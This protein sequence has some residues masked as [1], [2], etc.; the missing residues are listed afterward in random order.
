MPRRLRV[1]LALLLVAGLGLVPAPSSAEGRGRLAQ[2]RVREWLLD[3]A[4]SPLAAW[5]TADGA[6]PPLVADVRTS[7]PLLPAA[8][9][10]DLQAEFEQLAAEWARRR[11]LAGRP[12]RLAP[13]RGALPLRVRAGDFGLQAVLPRPGGDD[14]E[15][16][17]PYPSRWSLLP[18]VLA[19]AVAFALRSVVMALLA[20]G[21]AGAIAHVATAVPGVTLSPLAAGG[22]GLQHYV[23]DALW[24]R[25]LG[26]D[27]Y[28][29]ITL[30][31]LCLFVT[32]GVTTRNGG[33]HGFVDLLQRRVRG[34]VGAQLCTFAGGLL[35]FFDDYS[36]CLLNGTA[37]R[38]LTDR[39]RV[40]REKLA[41]LVDSTAAPVAGLSVVSTWV[42]YEMSQ[43]RLPLAQV[44]RADG[45]AYRP[46]DAFEVFLASLPYRCYSLFALGLVLLVV[47]LRRDF[48]PM[49]A[50][51]RRARRAADPTA[52]TADHAP[53]PADLSPH[54]A[55]PRRA[56]NALLPF[57]VL[58]FGT[59]GG[60]LAQGLAAGPPADVA[61][62]LG[63]QLRHLLAHAH[64]DRAML[65]ASIAAAATAFGL[66][67]GQRL[68]PFGEAVR[69]GA[70][71]ARMVVVPLAVLFLAWTLGH[72]CRDLGT[73]LF[74]AALVHDA[75]APALLPL[76][77]FVLAG[78]IAFATG[79]S[80]GTMAILLPNVVVLAHR[81]GT[82]AAFAGDPA[83]GGPALMLLCIAAVL[84]GAIF[85]DHCSP[86]SDTTV[87][88]SLGS[89]CDHL[90]HVVT[91]LPYA[92]LAGATT[93]LCG[94]LPLATLGPGWWP[95][96]LAGG[97]AAMAA[98][99]C[100]RGA[101]PGAPSGVTSTA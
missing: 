16:Q 86:I 27:F 68:L 83:T 58:L 76:L 101:D 75:L 32:L 37:M 65:W 97:L 100:W 22:Q 60:M 98:F 24:R 73:S 34:P 45:T 11:T 87:L 33:M 93:V 35:V 84:E 3:E 46:D 8:R 82:D 6:M 57:G 10:R 52:A 17:A 79:T 7:P 80:F 29:R 74:L 5:V 72:V 55:A 31:V 2:L 54:P 67:A 25:S 40:A 41:Y 4:A 18:A 90:A 12:T 28:L 91:Q 99:L 95:L 44:T 49:L 9:Q 19:I 78:A 59:L 62:G 64:S 48:G 85:G 13:D 81:L 1:F 30:F 43:Y 92:L 53:P 15:L 89:Q 70:R 94:Y 47:L 42:V 50:A 38:P 63:G 20:G 56:R 39:C 51:E 21:L 26:E 96:C 77:L 88:S 61:A 69:A 23:V 14:A 66:S 71:T 36:N